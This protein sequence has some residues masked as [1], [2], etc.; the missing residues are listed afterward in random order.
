MRILFFGRL[1]EALGGARELGVVDGET[2]AQLR[3]RLA[4]LNPDAAEELLSPR[5]R[6]CMDDSVVGEDFVV[7]GQDSVEF[8]PPLSGG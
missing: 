6:A 4:D 1:R 2:V 5:N 3:R 8:F 7:A